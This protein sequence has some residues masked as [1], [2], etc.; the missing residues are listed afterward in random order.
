MIEVELPNGDIAEF[1]DGTAPEM[2]QAVLR[3][4]FG[5]SQPSTAADVGMGLATGVGKGVAGLIGLP[6]LASRGADWLLEKGEQVLG[7]PPPAKAPSAPPN[8]LPQPS[9]VQSAMETVTGK[10]PSPQTRAGEYAQTIGEFIPG[11]LAGPGG[12]VRNVA[13]FGVIPGAASEAAGGATKGTALEPYAR[14]GAALATGGLAAFLTARGNAAGAVG[15]AAGDVDNATLQQ[16]EALFQEAQQLGTPITRAEAMQAVTG[17]ATNFG[18]LQRVVEGQGGMRDFFAQRAGQT[19]AAAGRV[20]DQVTPAAPNPSTIGP[21]VGNA[22]ENTINDVRGVINQASEPFYTAAAQQRIPGADM[23]RIRNA[24]G[25]AEARDAVRNDPQ[26]ARYV[27]G[28]PDNSVGFVNE[29]KKYLDTAAENAAAPINQQRNMQRSAGYGQDA[30]LMRTTAEAASPEYATALGIQR[31]AREQYLQ[32]LLDGPLGKIASRDT[33]TQKAINT[34]FPNNPL[35]NSAQEIETAVRAVS[36]RNPYAARQLVRA[37]LEMTFNEA[38]QNLASGVNSYGGAK[39]AAIVRGN[40]QQAANL[41]AAVRALPNGDNIWAGFDRFATMLEAQGQRQAIG[42][43][44]AFNQEVLQD[45][46]RGT[47]R[48][49]A[50][51]MALGLGVKAPARIK[52]AIERWRLGDN[53]DQIARL[54]T[55]PNAGREFARMA[56]V[57]NG[58]AFNASV[59]RLV[60]LAQRGAANPGQQSSGPK[61]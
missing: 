1:P 54:L 41:E 23:A 15:R 58:A 40:P 28:L 34:L 52:D 17:G 20:F 25:W 45:L 61:N 7:V 56:S 59:I 16:A 19:D 14:G 32:P 38:T 9:Q 22:A 30:T 43:Q 2:M 12:V 3:K 51:T 50:G 42:S 33:T 24:P 57:N 48:G 5:G 27:Q 13:A 53:V 6:G 18:N 10:F 26:L 35:P 21:A 37:H 55:D 8:L 39:F 44:T 47:A 60:G 49:E 31:Q 36:Q 4:Q 11:A 29:V 46:R